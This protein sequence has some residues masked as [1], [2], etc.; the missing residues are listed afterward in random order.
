MNI[1]LGNKTSVMFPK[2]SPNPSVYYTDVAFIYR[3][4]PK[5]LSITL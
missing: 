3:L 5:Y 2:I 1:L 4:K